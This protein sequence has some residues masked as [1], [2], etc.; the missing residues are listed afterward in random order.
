MDF[1]TIKAG[2]SAAVPLVRTMHIEYLELSDERALLR[3]PDDAAFHNHIG[4]L[5]AGAIFSLGESASGAIVIAAFNEQLARS[6]PLAGEASI[7]YKRVAMGPVLAEAR[8]GK[9]KADVVAELDSGENGRFPV[10]VTLTTED[11]TVTAEMTVVWVLRLN[12][13]A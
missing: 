1:D 12:R 7:T 8:L 10:E 6:V 2:L 4:G 9:A 3:L 11:G 5:H 13:N